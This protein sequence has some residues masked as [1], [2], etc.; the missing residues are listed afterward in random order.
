MNSSIWLLT[1]KSNHSHRAI[2]WWNEQK[3]SHLPPA[4]RLCW[5]AP[6]YWRVMEGCRREQRWQLA[7]TLCAIPKYA[8][9]WS[10][11]RWRLPQT[12]AR[13]NPPALDTGEAPLPW[14][15]LRAFLRLLLHFLFP[16]PNNPTSL[17]LISDK[18]PFSITKSFEVLPHLNVKKSKSLSWT[19]KMNSQKMTSCTILIHVLCCLSEPQ[20]SFHHSILR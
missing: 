18:I 20:I 5:V 10:N 19:Y 13:L 14:A 15:W 1:L 4:C 6:A 9:P 12:R 7:G 3:C 11:A 17:F 8:P 16:I 2:V